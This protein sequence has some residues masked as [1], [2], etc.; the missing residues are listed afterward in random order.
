MCRGQTGQ[1]AIEMNGGAIDFVAECGGLSSSFSG[2]RLEAAVDK[3][4][5]AKAKGI[6]IA[7]TH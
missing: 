3:H 2:L 7:A 6:C 4:L 1:F 5:R